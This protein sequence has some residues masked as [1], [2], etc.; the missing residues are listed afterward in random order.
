M[1]ANLHP[2]RDTEEATSHLVTPIL[3]A[4]LVAELV[5]RAAAEEAA[6]QLD[7]AEPCSG[8]RFH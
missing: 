3:V 5:I 7:A 4:D 1:S 2:A 8:K 6:G